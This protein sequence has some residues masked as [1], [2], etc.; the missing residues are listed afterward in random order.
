MYLGK[1][2]FGHRTLHSGTW[3]L[4]L[5]LFPSIAASTYPWRGYGHM[6][7]CLVP[8]RVARFFLIHDTKTDKNVTNEYKMHQMAIKYPK[9]Q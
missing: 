5:F 1:K 8:G 9:S 4:F 6:A 2:E 3:I 7:F